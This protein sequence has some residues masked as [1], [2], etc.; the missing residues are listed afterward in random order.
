MTRRAGRLIT[1][2]VF[3]VRLLG[4]ARLDFLDRHRRR[5]PRVDP[6]LRRRECARQPRDFDTAD[7][8][9]VALADRLGSD[10]A[11]RVTVDHRK[12]HGLF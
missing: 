9:P 6:D 10:Y 7:Q 5:V 3:D 12:D 2:L 4:E 1:L 11:A 8:D